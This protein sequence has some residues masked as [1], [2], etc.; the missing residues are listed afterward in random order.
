MKD[1]TGDFRGF[2]H[3][4]RAWYASSL[5]MNQDNVKDSISIGLYSPGGG[6]SG[7]FMIE[8]VQLGDKLA[9]RIA[10]FDDAWSALRHFNDLL[11][12]MSECDDENVTPEQF[13][14]ILQ[15]LGIQ[16]RTEYQRPADRPAMPT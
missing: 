5:P 10:A 4:G 7:E 2:T 1:H 13:C 16:N 14:R 6:T 12:K 3:T 9:P 11:E 8:W 15:S